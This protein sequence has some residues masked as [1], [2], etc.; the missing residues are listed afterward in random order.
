MNKGFQKFVVGR[1]YGVASSRT[2]LLIAAFR[3]FIPRSE[4]P[5]RDAFSTER[6]GRNL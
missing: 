2:Q 4:G 5:R 1:T 3:G 6:R